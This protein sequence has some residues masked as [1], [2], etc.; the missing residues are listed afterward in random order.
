M[1]T[2]L[3]LGV[4]VAV[5]F[6]TAAHAAPGA[7]SIG[8]TVKE[9][10]SGKTVHV[11]TTDAAGKFATASLQPGS[12]NVEFRSAKNSGFDGKQL[13]I[14]LSSG[15]GAPRK[16][17][18]IGKHLRAGV[19]VGVDLAAS[20]K[21]S[22]EV[23]VTGN[24]APEGPAPAGMEKVRANV[25]VI[26]GER[27][28]WVRA[29]VGSN[30]GGKWVKAGTEGAV[31]ATDKTRREDAEAWEKLRHLSEDVGPPRGNPGGDRR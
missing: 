9:K 31:L 23:L 3:R 8:V 25:K 29:P 24:E 20:S 30:M 19:A 12:Y 18:A 1:K 26:N 5:C 13:A 7:A 22:G 4:L 2:T 21:L 27:Y 10:T 28:V 17:T 16:A 11:A 6:A 15:K 14:S